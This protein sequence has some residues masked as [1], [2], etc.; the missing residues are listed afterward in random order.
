MT[1]A[2]M[3]V[4]PQ[5]QFLEECFLTIR[6]GIVARSLLEKGDI[7]EGAIVS[8]PISIIAPRQPSEY[9]AKADNCPCALYIKN[10]NIEPGDVFPVGITEV[11]YKVLHWECEVDGRFFIVVG[12]H[13]LRLPPAKATFNIATNPEWGKTLPRNIRSNVMGQQEIIRSLRRSVTRAEWAKNQIAESALT[14]GFVQTIINR[15]RSYIEHNKAIFDRSEAEQE[16]FEVISKLINRFS[17]NNRPNCTWGRAITMG[18]NQKLDRKAQGLDKTSPEIG[19]IRALFAKLFE[20]DEYLDDE[21][22]RQLRYWIADELTK[23]IAN[24]NKESPLEGISIAI[25]KYFQLHNLIDS[26][27]L[28]TLLDRLYDM[29]QEIDSHSTKQYIKALKS[30]TKITSLNL[31]TTSTDT[32]SG[33]AYE[34]AVKTDMINEIDLDKINAYTL[35][36]LMLSKVGLSE[37]EAKPWLARIGLIKT[38]DSLSWKEISEYCNLSI[39]ETKKEYTRLDRRIFKP[40]I[41]GDEQINVAKD[42]AIIKERAYKM[43]TKED[44]ILSTKHLKKMSITKEHG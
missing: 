9:F 4:N 42:R 2:T 22:I 3:A 14:V 35:V 26:P 34:P 40:Y 37:H 32:Q 38:V 1:I 11:Q 25:E 16:A 21:I 7:P 20:I 19:T 17:S 15:K 12:E 13:K 24:N 33:D 43:L 41:R 6:E 10:D 31:L 27:A 23:N 8:F 39:E 28:S 18:I 29:T 44:A 30:F 36:K 5:E